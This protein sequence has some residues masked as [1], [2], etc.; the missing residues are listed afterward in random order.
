[1]LDKFGQIEGEFGPEPHPALS[2]ILTTHGV[3]AYVFVIACA[4]LITVHMRL[5][6][7]ARRN[8]VSGLTLVVVSLLL[9]LSGLVLYYTTAEQLR[10]VASTAH[11]VIGLALPLALLVHQLRG[12]GQRRGGSDFS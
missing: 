4:M 5:G 8:R 10:G 12:K 7:Y 1:M 2:W 6:W 3:L 9:T 11:W